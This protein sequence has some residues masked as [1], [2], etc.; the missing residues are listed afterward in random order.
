MR[1][2]VSHE[3][4]ARVDAASLEPRERAEGGGDAF[5][6]SH[7]AERGDEKLVERNAQPLSRF[8]PGH[9]PR[10]GNAHADA[11]DRSAGTAFED[12]VPGRAAVDEGETA[13]PHQV[14]VER[15]VV[16]KAAASDAKSDFR[17]RVARRR[18]GFLCLGPILLEPGARPL[19]LHPASD[20]FPIGANFGA[21]EVVEQA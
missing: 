9:H 20:V 10:Q 4:V 14:L 15:V 18:V 2:P 21:L 1:N 16:E 11:P 7:Q 13:S 5:F 17:D 6:R 19:P 8:L 12:L 3:N